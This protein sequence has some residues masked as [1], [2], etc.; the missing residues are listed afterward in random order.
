MTMQGSRL[1]C[2]QALASE[3]FRRLWNQISCGRGDWLRL[4]QSGS[5]E[6]L[7]FHLSMRAIATCLESCGCSRNSQPIWRRD[8]FQ[9]CRADPSC[10]QLVTPRAHSTLTLLTRLE[11]T[12]IDLVSKN[13]F[14]FVYL[15]ESIERAY[16]HVECRSE[17]WLR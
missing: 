2:L 8:S 16:I 12:R 5:F 6:I 14:P 3:I 4:C 17:T 15:V 9:N 11:S 10:L 1:R 13:I 7:I